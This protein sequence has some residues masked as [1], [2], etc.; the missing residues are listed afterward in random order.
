MIKQIRER[1][2]FAIAFLVAILAASAPVVLAQYDERYQIAVV[3]QQVRTQ[4][5]NDLLGSGHDF[6]FNNDAV[7]RPGDVQRQNLITGSGRH[8]FNRSGWRTFT[9]EGE[10]SLRNGRVVSVDYRFGFDGG[11]D[12][13]GSGSVDMTWSGTVDDVV[14][15]TIRDRSVFSSG[16]NF[17]NA[18]P[19]AVSF[20]V[21]NPLP[22][23]PVNV[24]LKTIEGRGT[25]EV[26]EQPT[27]RNGFAAVVEIRDPRRGADRYVLEL[28]WGGFG[29]GQ[30]VPPGAEG[31]MNW[32]GNVDGTV[33]ILVQRRQATVTTVSGRNPSA[34]V[35]NFQRPLP[36]RAVD[37]NLRVIEG[38]GVVRILQQPNR[39]N[40]FAALIEIIDPRGG[41]DR[42][43]FELDWDRFGGDD[44][45][46]DTG[47]GLMNWRGSVDDVVRISVTGR[48]SFVTTISGRAPTG[49]RFDFAEALPRRAVNVTVDKREGRGDIRVIQQP[50]RR[51]NFTAV[52]EIVDR[53]GGRDNYEFDL[54][55]DRFGGG[56]EDPGSDRGLMNWRGAVDDIVRISVIGR[57][58]FVTTIS[59]Q[60]ASGVR[61]NFVEALPRTPLNVTVEKR[62]GRGDIRVIQQPSRQNNFTAVIEIVDR[63]GGRDTYEFDL[64]W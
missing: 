49:V 11:S 56:D 29:S 63:S 39:N 55:W 42:Y 32:Q 19:T 24:R 46:P 52:V 45:E 62:E 33:R 15:I 17:P 7:V 57:Q 3:Q 20:N 50:T 53:S 40:G 23:R 36:R 13:P 27:A 16:R 22:R 1:N 6:E 4:V 58:S 37:V 26:I 18:D 21:Y 60:A 5:V 43:A 14:R 41:A 9:Y 30:P 2:T 35:A 51:N 8:R 34:V 44:D 10:F 59:G 25:V 28:D 48:Q 47:G 38:R 12:R 64:F 54:N 31:G 61:Y